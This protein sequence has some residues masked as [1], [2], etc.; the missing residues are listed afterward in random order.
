MRKSW[1]LV[2]GAL[3]PLA[4]VA[5]QPGGGK[6]DAAC[7]K[8]RAQCM[9]QCD[10]EKRLWL[11]KGEAYESCAEK[12]DARARSCA[13]TGN[14]KDNDRDEADEDRRQDADRRQDDDRPRQQDRD[15][16]QDDAAEMDDDDAAAMKGR[17]KDKA[18]ER[19]RQDTSRGADD[20]EAEDDE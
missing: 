20:S 15:R 14:G 18:G 8:Q 17:N 1:V 10:K 9:K 4:A 3:L 2:V 16:G 5:G 13:A 19:R 7:E 12:C 6:P 11:F